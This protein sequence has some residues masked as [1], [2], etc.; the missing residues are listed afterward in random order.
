M[1]RK[2]KYLYVPYEERQEAKNLGVIWDA[3]EKKFFAPYYL[4]QN[5]FAKWNS[6]NTH[7][8]QKSY[9]A[10]QNIDENEALAQFKIALQ[11]QGFIIDNPI[12]NGKIQRCKVEGDRGNE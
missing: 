12:M 8:K 2:R 4:D 1:P 5:L 6:E 9:N 3:K 11:N 7:Q 10:Y